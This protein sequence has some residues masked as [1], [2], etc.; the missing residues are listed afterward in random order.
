ME[1]KLSPC[2]SLDDLKGIYL[3]ISQHP[4]FGKI[5]LKKQSGG[6]ITPY[7]YFSQLLDSF[8]SRDKQYSEE[9]Q[10][11]RETLFP[12]TSKYIP[13]SIPTQIDNENTPETTIPLSE[14]NTHPLSP[15]PEIDSISLEIN[16]NKKDILQSIK[17]TK[18]YYLYQR[19]LDNKC[20]IYV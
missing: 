1:I 12:K 17:G 16:T 6:A 19:Q 14:K 13:S 4:S 15:I 5:V 9:N 18:I 3:F 2:S 11:Q 7:I 20:T 10:K 8:F